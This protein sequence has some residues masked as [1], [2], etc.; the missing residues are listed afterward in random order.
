M[1]LIILINQILSSI[2]ESFLQP[3]YVKDIIYLF[4]SIF[5]GWIIIALFKYLISGWTRKKQG[6]SWERELFAFIGKPLRLFLP[7]LILNLVWP[8]LKIREPLNRE[9]YSGLTISSL[10]CFL[11]IMVNALKWSKGF[12]Y[13]IYKINNKGDLKERK[14]QTQI[15]FL[16]RLVTWIIIIL[17]IGTIL[18]S[19][20]GFRKIGTGL[21]TGVGISGIIIGFAA[22]KTVSNLLAGFQIA[23]T[24]PIRINDILVVEGEFGSVEEI[25]MT[26]VVLRIWDN[27]SL[28]LPINYFLEK[29]FINWTR[30]STEIIG[31]I[32]L[33]VDYSIPIENLRSELGR[34]LLETTLWDNKS[35]GLQVTNVKE[36]SIEIRISVSAKDSNDC[37]NLRCYLRENL[38]RFIN[39]NYPEGFPKSRMVFPE[40]FPNSFF[41][42]KS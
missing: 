38:I 5:I 7:I 39:K 4:A 30:T 23:F 31:T 28:I 14:I 35:S 10:L 11:W 42:Q 19:I 3:D 41:N 13:S 9:L 25:S 2:K 6:Y 20:S 29:P 33:Y 36:W 17:T 24:Q 32:F 18:L 40:S 21:L 26:Y 12:L 37:W 8:L 16:I 22:Q 27:R 1:N 15:Q 34:L